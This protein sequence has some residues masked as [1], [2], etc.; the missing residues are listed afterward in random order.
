M[1]AF[2]IV[3]W[4]NMFMDAMGEHNSSLES[5]L[6][7]EY[8][9]DTG[10]DLEP[11]ISLGFEDSLQNPLAG[12]ND[13]PEN[14]KDVEAD[15]NESNL[16]NGA[17]SRLRELGGFAIS[18]TSAWAEWGVGISLGNAMVGAGISRTLASLAIV[19]GVYKLESAQVSKLREKEKP[20]EVTSKVEPEISTTEGISKFRRATKRTGKFIVK[21]AKLVGRETG[22]LLS[23]SW[24]G[25][26][27]T[28][29]H[30]RAFGIKNTEKRGRLQSL[31]YGIAVGYWVSPL[32]GANNVREGA[33]DVGAETFD[34]AINNPVE[35]GLGSMAITAGV[36]YFYKHLENRSS[37]KSK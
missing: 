6:H 25:A 21:S 35:A 2:C 10:F 36:Y 17:I 33:K 7:E 16:S 22:A 29:N 28:M 19:A 20:I 1:L 30:N 24:Q 37:N 15:N 13:A 31:I 14:Y 32:P 34:Y 4:Y 3:F 8:L 27:A 11:A 23:A 12:A 26:P 5:G 9:L 18:R